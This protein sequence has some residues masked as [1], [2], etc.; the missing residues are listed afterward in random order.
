MPKF[1]DTNE[2]VADLGVAVTAALKQHGIEP[3]EVKVKV[4]PEEIRILVVLE[5]HSE[6]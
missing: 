4:S 3:E 6:V 1:I 2:V 5:D